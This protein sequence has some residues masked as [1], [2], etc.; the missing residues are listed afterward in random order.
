MGGGGGRRAVRKP[1]SGKDNIL[2]R[3]RNPRLASFKIELR[4]IFVSQL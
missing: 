3:S 2:I 4:E 1:A